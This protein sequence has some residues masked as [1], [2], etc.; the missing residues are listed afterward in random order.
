MP[1]F[2]PS[3]PD[4][5]HT[6]LVRM[7]RFFRPCLRASCFQRSVALKPGVNSMLSFCFGS[8]SL[9][10]E[11]E[12]M[13]NSKFRPNMTRKSCSELQL[14]KLFLSDVATNKQHLGPSP[15]L[16]LEG[17]TWTSWPSPKRRGIKIA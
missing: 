8:N 4:Y 14:L 3:C 15:T 2:K 12:T 16:T 10:A 11:L 17:S 6:L 9:Q 5:V 13:R 7:S 1:R